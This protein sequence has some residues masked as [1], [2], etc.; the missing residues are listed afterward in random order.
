[1]NLR[2][3]QF[4]QAREHRQAALFCEGMGARIGHT[5]YFA[6]HEDQDYDFVASWV[7]GDQQHLAPVQLKEV[8]PTNLNER[9]ELSSIT[10]LGSTP[11]LQT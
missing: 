4:K 6:A 8:V 5:V 10:D 2:T 1:M 9:A 11:A 3:N 7:V